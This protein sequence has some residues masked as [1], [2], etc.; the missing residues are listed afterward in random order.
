MKEVR[1]QV[2]PGFLVLASLLLFLDREGAAPAVL[3]AWLL[4]EG[5][6]LLLLYGMGGRVG[7]I[8]LTLNGVRIEAEKGRRFSYGGELLSVL[9]GPGVNLALALGCARLGERW[10][11]FSGTNLALGLFNLLPVPGLDGGRALMLLKLLL[12]KEE[13]KRKKE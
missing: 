7:R 2:S 13:K 5:G 6:H 9:A 11:L 4:H 12:E 1:V 10:Y 8:E 3:A